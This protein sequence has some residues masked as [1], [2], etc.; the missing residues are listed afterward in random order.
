M[1]NINPRNALI[2]LLS[3]AVQNGSPLHFPLQKIINGIRRAQFFLL[4]FLFSPTPPTPD[5]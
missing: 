5:R 3:G 2:L 1:N 4:F